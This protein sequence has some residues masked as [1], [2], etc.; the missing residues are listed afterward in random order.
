M[1][2]RTNRFTGVKYT[3]DPVIMS[4]QIGNEPRAFANENKEA[5][6]RWMA[7]VAAQIRSLDRNHLISSGS[8]GKHGCE[9]DIDLFERIHAD[10]NIDYMNI[11]IWPYNWGW[12]PKDS[13]QECLSRAIE[14][15]GKYIDEHLAVAA[16][17]RKPVVLEEFGFPRDGFRFSRESATNVRDAYYNY[18][19]DCVTGHARCGGLLAGCNFWAWGGFAEPSAGHV[20]WQKGDDYT[21]DPAQEEQGLNSVF[22]TDSTVRIIRSANERLA[23]LKEWK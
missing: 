21:G 20:F 2:T 11:H 19:F 17:Y 4:W 6:A 7:E 9:Q 15:T 5:F 22:V 1:I 23:G 3:D 8:E 16:K 14:H 12:A 18:V 13:L 10:A